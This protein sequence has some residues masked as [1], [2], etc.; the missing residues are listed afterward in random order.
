M[1]IQEDTGFMLRAIEIARRGEGF[2]NPNPLV[3]AVIV[4]NG[5]V[6]GEGFHA[7][8]GQPHAEI[9]AME[10]AKEN[11][12]G[13]TLYVTM[14]PCNHFGKTPPCSD[15]IIREKIGRLVFGI[16]DPNP[17]VAGKGAAKIAGSGIQVEGG[18]CREEVLRLNEVYIKYISSKIPFV[19]MKTAMT[20]DGK[21]ASANGDSKWITSPRSRE[22][23]QHLRHLYS[24]IMSG[25]GTVIADDPMLNDRSDHEEKSHPVRIICDSM[26]RTPYGSK[27]L[28]T[29]FSTLIAVAAGCPVS[30]IRKVEKK[31]KEVLIVPASNGQTD[32]RELVVMLGKRG[33]DSILLEAGGNLNFSAL[34]AGIVDKIIAFIAPKIIGGKHAASPVDG[35][36]IDKMEDA[37]QLNIT[38][39]EKSENDIKIEAYIKH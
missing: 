35:P 19:V 18:V 6:I 7:R 36:G 22:T 12:E 31:G 24:G 29:P 25:V 15:R 28:N 32:L 20:L 34:Q 9:N 5:R 37:I 2:V 21:I 33:I 27:V 23:V 1:G 3:G 38:G 4:K 13:A 39:M 26:G 14:E 11:L 17:D 16:H 10:N 8:Y 30:F